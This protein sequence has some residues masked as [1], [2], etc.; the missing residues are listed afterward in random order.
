MVELDE[1]EDA[2]DDVEEVAPPLRPELLPVGLDDLEH[3]C[4]A[5][6]PHVELATVDYARELKD[7]R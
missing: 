6:R 1:V 4:Q 7:D 3:H 2:E 5:A